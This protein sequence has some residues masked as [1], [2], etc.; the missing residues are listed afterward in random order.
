MT[1]QTVGNTE[2]T[3]RKVFFI[4]KVLCIIFVKN[5]ISREPPII[6]GS[7]IFPDYTD[8]LY[9]AGVSVMDLKEDYL[10]YFKKDWTWK[11]NS[12]KLWKVN[13]LWYIFFIS[14]VIFILYNYKL[15]FRVCW[16][17]STIYKPYLSCNLLSQQSETA[18]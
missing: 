6:I 2:T 3:R 13:G 5:Y 10:V 11:Q 1:E 14:K 7:R 17:R 9:S 16:F 18:C 12:F 8:V 15:L 4:C